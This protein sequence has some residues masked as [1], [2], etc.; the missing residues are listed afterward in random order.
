MKL[1]KKHL[2]CLL[3]FFI[4]LFVYTRGLNNHGF[5]YRDDEIFYFKST[6][7][8]VNTGNY[9][10]P[11]YFGEDRFQKPI[12][13]YWLIIFSYKIFGL[14]W[15]AARFVSSVFAALSIC[16]TFFIAKDLFSNKR[17]AT[18]SAFILMTIPMFYRH[19]KNAVPDMAL[20]YFII[21]AIY[22]AIRFVQNPQ[23][24]KYSILFFLSCGLGFMIKGFAALGF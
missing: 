11:T 13:F 21:L 10:S 14:N 7:E 23:K 12:L 24:Q 19:A 6:Q 5:E 8:M 17:I 15:F 3:L 4:G 1:S 2:F 22:C 16:T 20:N 9:L 18:L